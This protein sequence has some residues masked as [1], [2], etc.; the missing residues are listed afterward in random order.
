MLS[1]RG[2]ESIYSAVDSSNGTCDPN[3]EQGMI[4]EVLLDLSF[5]KHMDG[6]ARSQRL[7]LYF[8]FV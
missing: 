3:H 7:L 6:F 2:C 8:W 5:G 1:L 4:L